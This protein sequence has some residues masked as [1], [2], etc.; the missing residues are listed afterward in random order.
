LAESATYVFCLVQADR[1]PAVTGAPRVLP[2]A[3]APRALAIEGGLW[4]IVAD[5]PADRF[6]EGRLQQE[7]QDLEAVSRYALAHAST[8]E[9]FFRTAPVIPLTLFTLFSGDGRARAHL[10]K[11]RLA[12][13]KLFAA[14][15][16]REEWGVRI[17]GRL[18]PRARTPAWPSTGRG[19]LEIKKRLRTAPA[20]YSRAARQEIGEAMKTLGT[21]ATRVRKESFPP[22]GPG[23][24]YMAGA[25][26]LVSVKRRTA[27][28]R[29]AR[30]LVASLG[31][32][33][34]RLELSGP[35]PPYHF[36][37]TRRRAR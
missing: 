11:R 26:F 24:A 5:A 32:H 14:L 10:A 22:P 4:A 9:F 12:L 15:R 20:A 2:G 34:H 7:L 25:S 13:R 6:S 23:R 35:W 21:L 27:W 28:K 18:E 36:I 8:I 37:S 3:G 30:R 33:G 31:S 29:E 16:G 1:A 17:T 19:Y